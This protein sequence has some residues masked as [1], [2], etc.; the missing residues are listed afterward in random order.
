MIEAISYCRYFRK[1]HNL[2]DGISI[3]S[4]G[5][6]KPTMERENARKFDYSSTLHSL[7]RCWLVVIPTE[8]AALY[9]CVLSNRRFVVVCSSD[10]KDIINYMRALSFD[11]HPG[12]SGET[13]GGNGIPWNEAMARGATKRWLHYINGM[14]SS[15]WCMHCQ[16]FRI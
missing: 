13:K 11:E 16:F 1:Y 8:S 15:M 9:F 7:S 2:H 4:T 12:A 6:I 3:N 14:F 5:N 10:I